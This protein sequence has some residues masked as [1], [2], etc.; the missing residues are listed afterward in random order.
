[1]CRV[2]SIT[3]QK[4]GVGKSTSAGSLGVGLSLMGKKVMVIDAD[5]QGSLSVSL[6]YR[7]PDSME[8]TLAT[9]LEKVIKEDEIADG[10]GILHHREGVDLVPCNIELAALE[11]SMVNV[12]SRETVLKRYVDQIRD[13]YDYILIDCMPSLNMMTINA[14]VAT[15]AVIIPVQ[16][17]YLPVK[18]LEQLLRTIK[19]VRKHLNP[20]LIIDG[21]V[22][23]MAD[24][25]TNMA[26]D[27]T[28]KVNELY[29]DRLPVFHSVIPFSVRAAE[30][31]AEGVS[32][33]TYDPNGKVAAAYDALVKEVLGNE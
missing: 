21:I 26:R 5:S 19:K 10:E 22:I 4:G 1:M 17:N 32:I 31:A 30:T 2:I 13:D 28:Q 7:E 25:R 29:G 27:V 24:F 33:F 12:I 8:V 14:L 23:T 11:S 9:L 18:G 16:A 6:G 3:N 20:R 15:D